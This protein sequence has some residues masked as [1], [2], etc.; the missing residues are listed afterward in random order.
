MKSVKEWV[1]PPLD[2]IVIDQID[3]DIW[4]HVVNESTIHSPI[5]EAIF[6]EIYHAWFSQ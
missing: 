1:R 5:V 3:V 6:D 4:Y 2:N